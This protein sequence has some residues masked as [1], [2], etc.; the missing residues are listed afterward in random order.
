MSRIKEENYVIAVV[1]ECGD[2]K[3]DDKNEF[4]FQVILVSEKKMGEKFYP[5]FISCKSKIKLT[6]SKTEQRLKVQQILIPQGSFIKRIY[7][8]LALGEK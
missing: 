2:S 6:P 7:K 8:I 4:P 5:E 3:A 1:E